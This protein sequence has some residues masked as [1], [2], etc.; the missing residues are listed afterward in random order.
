MA[1]L[2]IYK[3]YAINHLIFQDCLFYFF[4]HSSLLFPPFQ[5]KVVNPNISTF[6]EHLSS[7]RD[8]ISAQMAAIEIGLPRIDPELSINKVTIVSLKFVF[9]PSYKKESYGDR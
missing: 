2:Q 5:F 6:T 8:K 1:C 9:F 3:Q 4:N 7:V